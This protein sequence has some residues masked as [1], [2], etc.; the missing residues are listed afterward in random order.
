[1]R[2]PPSTSAYPVFVRYGRYVAR[3]LRRA[4]LTH[5]A[6]SAEQVTLAA[7]EAG[8]A[9]E[10]ADDAIQAALADR[11]AA[12]DDLDATAQQ[13]R[14]T[15]LGRNVGAEREEP[16]T[17][18]FPKGIGYYTAAP[19][20]QNARRYGELK[21]RAEGHLP[22]SDAARKAVLK[23]VDNGVAALAEAEGALAAAET[24][25]GLAATRARSALRAFERQM[26]KIY[27][28]LVSESGKSAAE[29]F[30]PKTR[31]AKEKP[32]PTPPPVV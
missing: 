15:L 31:V 1:M 3:R 21:Q 14:T 8:R 32:A 10:D 12:D 2:L 19:V 13:L 4:G 22:A 27:G 16:Y 30:F 11:D 5:L 24:T 23:A 7:R 6:E 18:I 26:E 17:L 20:D 29:R 9:W 28:A 25:D